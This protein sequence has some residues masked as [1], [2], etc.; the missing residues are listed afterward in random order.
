MEKQQD[1][2]G[3]HAY[4]KTLRTALQSLRG[5]F[6]SSSHPQVVGE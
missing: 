3:F 5:G 6:I 1:A 2:E 4:F